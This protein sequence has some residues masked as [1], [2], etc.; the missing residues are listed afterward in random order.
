MSECTPGWA[1][2]TRGQPRDFLREQGVHFEEVDIDQNSEVL[3]VVMTV[4]EGK[5][6]TLT[7]DVDGRIFHCSLRLSEACSRTRI[8]T[9][10]ILPEERAER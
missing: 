7:F 6:R 10:R 5:Q 1:A 9:H 8:A 2:K 4:N 3:A